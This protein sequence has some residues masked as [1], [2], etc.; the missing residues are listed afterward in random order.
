MAATILPN[1]KSQFIDSNGKPLAGGS[2]YFYIPNTSTFKNTWQDPA[3]TILNTNPIVLDANGQA[4]IWGAGT[5]RQ[6]VYDQFNNLIWD[7]IT[8]DTSS[9]LI[10]NMTDNA[11]LSGTGF[12]PGTTTTLTISSSPGSPANMW[13]FFDGAYQTPDTWSV[14]GTVVTFNS[15]IPIGVNEVNIKVG[16]TIAI[17]TP[18]SGSVT[19][20]SVATNA[21]IQSSK[22]SYNQGSSNAVNRTVKSR[23]QDF[24][25]VKDFGAKGDGVT[26]DTSAFNNAIANMAGHCL[27]VP[28]GNYLIA[29]TI[30]ISVNNF[31]LLGDFEY[32]TTLTCNSANSDV[33]DITG[34]NIEIAGF[35]V[36]H[37]VTRTG[38]TT[39]NFISG[40][41]HTLRDFLIFGAYAA[42]SC[43]STIAV[44]RDGQIRNTVATVGRSII[45]GGNAAGFDQ[46]IM[47]IVMD[48]PSGSQPAFGIIVNQTNDLRIVQCEIQ[49]QGTGMIISPGTSQLAFAVWADN[50]FFDSSAQRGVFILPSSTGSVSNVRFSNCWFGN[51]GSHGCEVNN[52][53]T[54]SCSSIHFIDPQCVSNTGDGILLTKGD[55]VRI[56]GGVFEQNSNGF[57]VGANQSDWSIIGASL[58]NFG[59]GTGNSGHGITIDAGS[60]TNFVIA[61]CDIRGNAGNILDG[62]SA[63]PGKYIHHNVGYKT[64]NSG[65]ATLLS[66]NSSVIVSHGLDVQPQGY[67]FQITANGS[68][69]AAGISNFWVSAVTATTFTISAN[70]SATSNLGFGWSVNT[71]GA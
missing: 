46:L 17:G 45:I 30:N 43:S 23:L 71:A 7:Q 39:F 68:P 5:Y 34:S 55:D 52:S 66:G 25:T 16:N 35:N 28:A 10:G 11:Y 38:G 62:S 65:S 12:T 13:V 40:S 63:S 3:Q 26:D 67:E 27:Y 50:T 21:G 57:H 47:N 33:F 22:L 41:V 54:G 14:S 53:G 36:S 6:V 69:G 49:H 48:A 29:G 42:I 59:G 37:S 64:S 2:V 70:A 9:G 1:A 8:E 20:S 51:N 60:S 58:G 56:L 24:V 32:G 44:I 15:A 18:G 31:K 4:L 61:N 19:D